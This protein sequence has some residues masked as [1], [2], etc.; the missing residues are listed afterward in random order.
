MADPFFFAGKH[1]VSTAPKVS[2]SQ[3]RHRFDRRLPEKLWCLKRWSPLAATTV[4]SRPQTRVF[5]WNSRTSVYKWFVP[6]G[7]RLGVTYTPHMSRHALATD[8]RALGWDMK[9]IAERGIWRDERSGRPVH[10]S[11]CD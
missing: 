9:A 7:Q 2:S 3:D 6:L 4:L 10:P 1:Q 5:P 8:L 11:P